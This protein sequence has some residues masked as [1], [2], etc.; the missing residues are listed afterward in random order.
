MHARNI[1]INSLFL[2]TNFTTPNILSFLLF[3]FL[4]HLI[5]KLNYLLLQ[6]LILLNHLVYQLF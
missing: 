5:F 2:P 6:I 1:Y 3:L 4:L